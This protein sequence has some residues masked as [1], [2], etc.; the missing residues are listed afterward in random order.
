MQKVAACLG[1]ALLLPSLVWAD[2]PTRSPSAPNATQPAPAQ[3]A[4]GVPGER[5]AVVAN[6]AA[7]SIVELYISPQSAE[8]WGADRLGED[9][10]DSTTQRLFRLG[11]MP[12]CG[13]DLL[14]IYDDLSREEQRGVNLCR[15]HMAV[16]D[17]RHATMPPE[18]LGPARS[19]VVN[20][21]SPMPI[22]QVFISPPDAAQWG[23]DLLAVAAMSVGEQRTL[24]FHGPCAAD[25][26]VVFSNRAAEERRGLDL[27]VNPTLRIVPGWT[28]QDRAGTRD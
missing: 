28:T 10:L 4:P 27:C 12:D 24:T 17:G 7:H 6:H 13:F 15:V 9:V 11:R 26:R 18:T 16:F 19:V 14:A 25:V 22:Q 2:T 3:I 8:T 20:D 5:S 21:A 1:L 23:D